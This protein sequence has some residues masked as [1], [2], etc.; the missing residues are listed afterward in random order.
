MSQLRLK[1]PKFIRELHKIRSE[2]SKLPEEERIKEE[3]R[4][5]EKYR[6][7]LGHLYVED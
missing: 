4:L 7:R 3:K 6:G 2:L 1:E 5:M